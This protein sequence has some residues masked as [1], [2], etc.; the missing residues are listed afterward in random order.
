MPMEPP[1]SS[2]DELDVASGSGWS[3]SRLTAGRRG[4]GGGAW[5][6]RRVPADVRRVASAC[7]LRVMY[8][9]HVPQW[10]STRAKLLAYV[11]LLRRMHNLMMARAEQTSAQSLV[12][13]S[14]TT[15]A[16]V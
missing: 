7:T 5:Q 1:P 4:R 8:G 6:V 16:A 2:V 13:D 10:W 14:A 9:G 3:S 11:E 12:D 15:F